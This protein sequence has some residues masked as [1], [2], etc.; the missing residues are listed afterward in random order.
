[1]KRETEQ[2]IFAELWRLI[3]HT[4]TKPEACKLFREMRRTISATKN[5]GRIAAR[6]NFSAMEIF[7]GRKN[8][9]KLLTPKGTLYIPPGR[10]RAICEKVGEPA[11]RVLASKVF[12]FVFGAYEYGR[13]SALIIPYPGKLSPS[14]KEALS[15]WLAACDFFSLP[16]CV[17]IPQKMKAELFG[18]SQEEIS[19]AT[20]TEEY[21]FIFEKMKAIGKPGAFYSDELCRS[22]VA[23]EKLSLVEGVLLE[24]SFALSA[25]TLSKA[26]F[27][28][29]LVKYS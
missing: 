12:R 3:L 16:R 27:F 8:A 15:V 26:P 5:A 17:H 10:S 2:Q 14:K 1:M 19:T 28:N 29:S 9:Q 20:N 13:G 22:A 6:I 11:G 21:A 25:K 24:N 7:L 4:P 18:V 23:A